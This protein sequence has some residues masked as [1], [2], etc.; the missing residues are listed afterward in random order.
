MGVAGAKENA[1]VFESAPPSSE[2]DALLAEI[3][4]PLRRHGRR[5]RHED[6]AW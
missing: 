2:K 4:R 5:T 3:D 1:N 6:Q